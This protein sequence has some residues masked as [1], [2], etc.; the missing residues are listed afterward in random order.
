MLLL[1][2]VVAGHHMHGAYCAVHPS[3]CGCTMGDGAARGAGNTPVGC[4]GNTGMLEAG[5]RCLTARSSR[6]GG[7]AIGCGPSTG[8]GA[9]GAVA[10]MTIGNAPSDAWQPA[11]CR[12][13]VVSHAGASQLGT[14][15]S[16]FARLCCALTPVAANPGSQTRATTVSQLARSTNLEL[17]ARVRKQRHA[18][19]SWYWW[20]ALKLSERSFADRS[21]SCG[22]GRGEQP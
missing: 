12:S 8:T 10:A 11:A 21:R 5:E 20:N 15:K 18:L 1:G 4:C 14:Q 19:L 22:Q 6:R 9:C 17:R 7:W 2:P 16:E 13:R 3:F